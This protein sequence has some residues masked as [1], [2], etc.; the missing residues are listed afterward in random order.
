MVSNP[1]PSIAHSKYDMQLWVVSDASYL[2]MSKSRSRVGCFH[3]LSHV[4]D[5]TKPLPQQHKFLNSPIHVE[6][7]ILKPVVRTTSESEIA[8]GC[9]NARKAIPF[10][11]SV[12][13]IAQGFL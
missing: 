5:S 9:V 4:P 11:T 10:R 2:S 13:Y 3:Y 1:D 12:V 8:A 6:A 7:S